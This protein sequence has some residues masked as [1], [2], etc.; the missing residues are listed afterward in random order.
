M[1]YMPTMGLEPSTSPRFVGEHEFRSLVPMSAAVAA[2]RDAFVAVSST[3][4]AGHPARIV[5]GD[6]DALAMLARLTAGGDTVVK[7]VTVRPS[8]RERG[9]PTIHSVLVVFDGEDGSPAL[10]LDGRA[11][12][13]VRTGAASAVATDVLASRDASI[14]AVI[15]SG[16]QAADQV[17]GVCAVRE[18]AEV[19]LASRNH[20][21]RDA[22]AERI[23][24]ERPDVR[25][26]TCESPREAVATADVI[27]CATTAVQPLFGADDVKTGVH[28]NAIGSYTPEMCELDP[29]LLGAARVIAVDQVAAALTEAGEVIRAVAAGVIAADRLRELG[30]IVGE[31]A[32]SFEGTTVFK[33]VGIAAQDW[34]VGTLARRRLAAAVAPE[35]VGLVER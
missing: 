20:A 7:A 30:A 19:R 26:T 1:L 18:I 32:T 16:A 17:E 31:G 24:K 2:V 10:L 13:A 12:T 9:L 25:V 22:L 6:G 11:V 34:A 27:C 5:L 23:G 14:L 8:N 33:S 29:L 3:A 35:S 4:G 21:T 28:I 15:G